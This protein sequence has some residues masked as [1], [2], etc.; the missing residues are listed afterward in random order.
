MEES[1]QPP[2]LSEESR[3]QNPESEPRL[4]RFLWMVL[5]LHIVM[6]FTYTW[7]IPPDRGPDEPHHLAYVVHLHN[8]HELPHLT[9]VM[10]SRDERDNAIAIH[11][12]LYYV[13]CWPVYELIK[14]L[15]RA[16]VERA[17][18]WLAIIM[19]AATVFLAWR[20]GVTLFPD[21]PEVALIAATFMAFLPE[22][23]MLSAV[24]NND[25]PMMLLSTAFLLVL[26]RWRDQ[27]LSVFRWGLLGGFYGVIVMT[28]ASGAA[29]FPVAVLLL[30]W[31][32]WKHRLT[33]I[34]AFLRLS[35]FFVPAVAL[36]A[37]WFLD[38]YSRFGRI[39]PIATWHGHPLIH[40]SIRDLL[41]SGRG[42]LCVRRFLIGA[43]Q[44]VWGQVDWFLPS[45]Q[46]RGLA[47]FPYSQ[48]M[49]A[50]LTIVSFLS[51][52]GLIGLGIRLIR[53]KHEFEATQML[54]M[55]LLTMHF[56]LAYTSLAHFTLFVHPGGYQGGRYL[57]PSVA[58]FSTLFALGFLSVLPQRAHRFL[59]P[60]LL[61]G[62]VL[63]NIFC[64]LNLI[65]VLNPLYA[66]GEG[67]EWRLG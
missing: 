3:I 44:S 30:V 22:F 61:V 41:T 14:G 23:Q 13:A 4:P 2:E 33:I 60:V 56:I 64:A 34:D 59:A 17:F 66:P 62:L 35:A 63:W 39:H 42:W 19:G 1:K 53:R 38:I 12:P 50:V 67:I 28:K 31:H 52:A 27:P 46:I 36:S 32:W 55:G 29:V 47:F 45:E 9:S 7:L 51:L 43:Q 57:Y 11:P 8:F 20:I 40:E 54:G 37:W 65:G 15:P 24:M 5:G 49:Y 48:A 18:R 58:A 25:G 6:A 16:S 26:I 21:R 10:S